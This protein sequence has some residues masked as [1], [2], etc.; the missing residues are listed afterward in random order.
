MRFLN[1]DDTVSLSSAIMPLVDII[2]LLVVFFLAS[3]TFKQDDKDL[4]ITLPTSK[5]K[6]V[7]GKSE[8]ITWK[9]NIKKD[10]R[11]YLVDKLLSFDKIEE[12]LEKNKPKSKK[13]QIILRADK[14]V[15][16]GIVV[17]VLGLM[18]EHGYRKIAF[19]SSAE[20]KKKAPVEKNN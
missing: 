12:M 2:F 14:N 11:I 10:S 18:D 9:I 15:P 4:G 7:S 1:E 5:G 3:S 16:Y 8:A 6:G 20:A 19:K 17:R 13:I